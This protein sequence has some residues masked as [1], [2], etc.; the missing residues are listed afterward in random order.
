MIRSAPKFASSRAC[1]SL[2]ALVVAVGT[3]CAQ[4]STDAGSSPSGIK[5]SATITAA[6]AKPVTR[7]IAATERPKIDIQAVLFKFG[8]AD[9]DGQTSYDQIK[10]LGTA[11]SDSRL[12]GVKL[13]VQGH[14]DSVGSDDYNLKLSQERAN[15][16]VELLTSLYGI[17]KENLVPVG[18]G[19]ADPVADNET[20]AGRAQNR[21]VTIERQN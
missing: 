3:A 15:K 13:E 17:P 16:V 18:K 12:K 5:S 6:L 10:E 1:L 19:K 4:T 8:T 7:S 2:A 20:E 21:R 14:T 9:I 11:L